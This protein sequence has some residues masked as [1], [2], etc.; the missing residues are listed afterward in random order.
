MGEKSRRSSS[1]ARPARSQPRGTR[2]FI[3][4]IVV[5]AIGV[6]FIAVISTL[7]SSGDEGGGSAE[8]TSAQQD[9]TGSGGDSAQQENKPVRST[10]RVKQGDSF[11]SISE[12]T[13]VP[14]ETL[15]ELNPEIDPRALQPG[16]KLKLK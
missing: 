8:Q 4:L 7:A 6:C 2:P 14:I 3:R 5:L 1:P 15:Q 16:Q 10:Y 12:K 11:A 9:D 13:G